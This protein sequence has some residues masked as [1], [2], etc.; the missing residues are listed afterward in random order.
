MITRYKTL[1]TLLVAILGSATI[2]MAGNVR[3]GS[4][5]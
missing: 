5:G 2:A 4:N 1:V 3:Y